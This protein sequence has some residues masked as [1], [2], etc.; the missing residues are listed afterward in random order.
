MRDGDVVVVFVGAKFPFVLRKV[1]H[2]P[3]TWSF[4]GYVYV[5]GIMYGELIEQEPTFGY[6]H[7]V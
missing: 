4:V 3:E 7:L 2:E 1:D 5:Q 6:F